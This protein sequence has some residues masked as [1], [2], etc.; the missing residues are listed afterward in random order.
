MLSTIYLAQYETKKGRENGFLIQMMNLKKLLIAS[1]LVGVFPASAQ[2]A[3]TN[4]AERLNEEWWA[5]RHE[6]VLDQIKSNPNP[7][8]ILLGDSITQNYEKSLPLDENF[9]PT[10]QRFYSPRNAPERRLQRRSN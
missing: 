5:K 10:W 2:I 1:M 8:V 6:R 4:P 3:A 9:L 7:G